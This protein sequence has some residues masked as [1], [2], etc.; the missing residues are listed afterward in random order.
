MSFVPGFAPDTKSQCLELSPILQE[1]VLD[2]MERLASNSPPPPGE[3]FEID[4]AATDASGTHYVFLRAIVDRQRMRITI[5]GIN[6]YF[7]PNTTP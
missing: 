1:L 2:E 4:F 7:R 5:T 3:V 6:R